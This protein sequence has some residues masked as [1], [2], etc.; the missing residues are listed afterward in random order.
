[1]AGGDY[2]A[3]FAAEHRRLYGYVH[4]NR[5]LEI[6]AARVQAIGRSNTTMP[7][8]R[9]ATAITCQPHGSHPIYIEGEFRTAALYNR[10]KLP[11]GAIIMGPAILLEPLTTTI[12]DPG[13]Q[14]TVFTGGELLIEHV[15]PPMTDSSAPIPGSALRT[16]SL[17]DPILLEVYSNHFTAI[18]TQMG[19]T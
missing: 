18:A 16:P 8:S 3:A 10:E 11:P 1:P 19:I 17:P 15:A 12:I 7:P 5:A 9:P 14:G 6:V 13:W 4:E 2:A